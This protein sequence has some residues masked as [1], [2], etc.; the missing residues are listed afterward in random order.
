MI[1]LFKKDRNN[2]CSI[3]YINILDYIDKLNNEQIT[4]TG[5]INN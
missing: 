1:S 3:V 4:P 5:K 2:N